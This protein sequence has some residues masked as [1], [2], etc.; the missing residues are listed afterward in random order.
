MRTLPVADPGVPESRSASRYFGWV[1]RR[2]WRSLVGAALLG[3]LWLGGQAVMPAVLGRAVD[4]GLLARDREALLWWSLALAGLV[5]VQAF[6][7]MARHRLAVF[8]WLAATYR[9]MQVTSRQAV[10]LGSSLARRMP[11]GEVVSIA[12]SDVDQVGAAMDITARGSGAV[13]AIVIVGVLMLSTSVPLGLIVVVGVPVLM[14]VVGLLIRPLHVRQRAYRAQ[15]AELTGRANDI[16][17]GLRVLRGIGGEEVFA[18]RYREQSQQVRVA[19]MRV[20]R[21]ESLLDS[22]QVLLP[23]TFVVL[24]AWVGARFALDGEI[25]VGQLIAFYAY[26]AFLTHPIR[27][28]I[29]AVDKMT[30]GHVAARR[31]VRFL[32]FTPDLTDPVV[33][34]TR[35]GGQATALAHADGE[36]VDP[37]T[38][39]TVRP[40]QLTAVVATDPELAQ[41]IADR[42]ARYVDSDAALGD[43]PLARLPLATVRATIMLAD[44]DAHLF[45]GRLRDQLDPHGLADDGQVASAVAAAQAV[46]IVDALPDG[47]ETVVSARGRDFSGGQQQ[48]LRLARMLLLD[49]PILLLVEPTSAVDA[50]TEA[51]VATALRRARAGRTTVVFGTSPLLLDAA[52]AVAFVDDG[53]VAAVGAHRELLDTHR[54]YAAVVTREED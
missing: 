50:H 15:Q 41:R 27:H 49:P 20:A 19:G 9:T 53:R 39:V 22:A 44:N 35:V 42:L 37:E 54:R 31:V 40:G 33:P 1:A 38:G 5:A 7:G 17:N 2:Q 14:A 52:D 34:A 23:G 30:R 16:V 32:S 24:V 3:V 46:D 51:R 36:L 4:A 48:R 26:A 43:V 29:E 10:R 8:N 25:T 13:A 12:T 21:V 47:L 45:A 28:L 6:A 11:T 18:G